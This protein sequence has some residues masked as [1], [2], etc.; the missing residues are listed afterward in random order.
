MEAHFNHRV[1]GR[2]QEDLRSLDE[3]LEVVRVFQG[4]PSGV[5]GRFLQAFLS[6]SIS[7]PR[8]GARELEAWG[9]PRTRLLQTSGESSGKRA[10]FCLRGKGSAGESIQKAT[11]HG[12]HLSLSRTLS[13]TLMDVHF[14]RVH[15]SVDSVV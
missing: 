4:V 5:S 10:A 7:V 13:S 3:F 9:S 11:E 12:R 6:W 15:R 2:F 14:V 1:V 8:T